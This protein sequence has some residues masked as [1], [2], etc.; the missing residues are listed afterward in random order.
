[1]D[2]CQEVHDKLAVLGAESL[3]VVLRDLETGKAVKIPQDNSLASKAPKIYPEM[4]ELDWSKSAQ[5]IKNQ[6]HGLSPYP[7]AYSHFKQKRIKFLRAKYDETTENSEPG[8][9]VIRDKKH[10]GIQ[11]G[12]GVLY[13][14]ELQ[15]EGKREMSVK[16]FL[17]GFQGK[18]GDKFNS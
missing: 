6:I 8:T 17:N 16:D 10:L 14:V 15:K 4:G 7:G 2:T 13:P 3:P 5:E 11:T 18:I 1:M 12:N 9:I